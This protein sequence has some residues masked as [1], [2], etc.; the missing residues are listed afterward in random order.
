MK[1]SVENWLLNPDPRNP[2][3][4]ATVCLSFSRTAMFF[5]EA[6]KEDCEIYGSTVLFQE[7]RLRGSLGK[8]V[9]LRKRVKRI[10]RCL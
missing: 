10:A 4:E 9:R 3:L 6:Q 2:P 7:N 1:H 5:E 8:C